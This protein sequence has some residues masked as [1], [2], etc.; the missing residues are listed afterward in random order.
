MCT[1]S[2]VARVNAKLSVKFVFIFSN[3]CVFLMTTFIGHLHFFF[4]SL[5]NNFLFPCS[6]ARIDTPYRS[7]PLILSFTFYSQ[8]SKCVYV[9]FRRQCLLFI[10]FD[11]FK[12]RNCINDHMVIAD[13]WCLF[14]WMN[15]KTVVIGESSEGKEI[16]IKATR[17]LSLTISLRLTNETES[18]HTDSTQFSPKK[19]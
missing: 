7:L 9:Y 2:C 6:V 15:V 13:L 12:E 19:I 3:I 11:P 10:D 16:Q 4:F 8:K 14:Y 1:L 17:S 5:P 18:A